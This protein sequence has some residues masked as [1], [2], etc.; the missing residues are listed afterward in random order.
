[1]IEI[2]KRIKAFSELGKEL[3]NV[4][5][6]VMSPARVERDKLINLIYKSHIYNAWFTEKN[7]KYA[8]NAIGKSLLNENLIKWLAP[9]QQNL[10]RQTE[11]KTIGVV[12]AGNL[13]LVGF[14]DFVSVL[15]S[16]NRIVAKLSS[17]DNKL[18]PAIADK[19]IKIEPEFLEY[20]EFTEDKFK[21]FDAIIA[22]GS[23]NSARYFEYYFSK[24]P[25]IIRKNRNGVA[26]LTGNGLLTPTGKKK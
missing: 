12:M 17:D 14:H 1:M 24:Y 19:L 10:V 5:D 13:P 16:G 8:I 15:M 11:T 23:N 26:I 22:T 21:N 9:Y 2:E 3:V 20:I 18:L 6:K 25:N 7:V 4:S